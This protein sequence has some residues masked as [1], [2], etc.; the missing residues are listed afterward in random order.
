MCALSLEPAG[1][2]QL[3]GESPLWSERGFEPSVGRFSAH[4][5]RCKAA[6]AHLPLGGVTCHADSLSVARNRWT[7]K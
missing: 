7:K 4:G 6:Y 3:S 1:F 5:M 2:G